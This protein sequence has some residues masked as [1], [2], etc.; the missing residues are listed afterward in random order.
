MLSRRILLVGVLGTV[1][2]P[3]L[4][5]TAM[6]NPSS[7]PTPMAAAAAELYPAANLYPDNNLHPEG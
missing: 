5:N 3:L 7:S 6:A 2:L 1:S 4:A